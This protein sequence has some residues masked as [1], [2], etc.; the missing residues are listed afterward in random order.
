VTLRCNADPKAPSGDSHAPV[1]FLPRT[2]AGAC[3]WIRPETPRSTAAT[4]RT[5]A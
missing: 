4:K 5:A 3:T 2:R 1:P